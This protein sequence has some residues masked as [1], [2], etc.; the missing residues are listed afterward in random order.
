MKIR[1]LICGAITTIAMLLLLAALVRAEP[2][3]PAGPLSMD[4]YAALYPTV[5]VNPQLMVEPVNFE[6][7]YMPVDWWPW[8]QPYLWEARCVSE[9]PELEEW[10]KKYCVVVVSHE[11]HPVWIHRDPPEPVILR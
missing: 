3:I 11:G 4:M 5:P 9:D 8:P 7:E 10:I 1:D 2:P 6:D